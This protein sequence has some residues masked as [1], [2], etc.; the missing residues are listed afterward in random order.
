MKLL[1]IVEVDCWPL[2]ENDV[3]VE[4]IFIGCIK[5]H[6]LYIDSLIIFWIKFM[7]FMSC[8]KN[9]KTVVLN[10]MLVFEFMKWKPIHE[11]RDVKNISNG[12]D[13]GKSK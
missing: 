8:F 5:T 13:Y 12:S 9:W 6:F 4:T 2:V 1:H 7:N 3:T 11:R 10:W